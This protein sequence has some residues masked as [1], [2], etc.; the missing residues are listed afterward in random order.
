MQNNQSET[1]AVW[2]VYILVVVAAFA[3]T[4]SAFMF[5][6]SAQPMDDYDK[7]A[8]TFFSCALFM[9]GLLFIELVN[10]FAILGTV[11]AAV[12]TCCGLYLIWSQ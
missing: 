1:A 8:R 5:D 4:L 3:I 6:T 12:F 2:Q 11:I 9:I 10:K 7:I